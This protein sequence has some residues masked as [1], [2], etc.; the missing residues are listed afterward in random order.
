M[1]SVA[2]APATS[3]MLASPLPRQ[4]RG[5]EFPMGVVAMLWHSKKG[6][7]LESAKVLR[8]VPP[9]RSFDF[10][11][12]PFAVFMVMY[13]QSVRHTTQFLVTKIAH[14]EKENECL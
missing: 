4:K 14:G 3:R 6:N 12:P 11:L 7:C 9:W 10:M 13:M 8:G 5:R 1:P 2:R